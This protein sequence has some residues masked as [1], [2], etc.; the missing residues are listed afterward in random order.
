MCHDHVNV[1]VTSTAP[2]THDGPVATAGIMGGV[3]GGVAV[4]IILAIL[5]YCQTH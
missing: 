2:V 4:L 5:L 3:V 1:G